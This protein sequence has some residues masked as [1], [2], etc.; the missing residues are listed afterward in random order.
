[1]IY[2]VLNP[3]RTLANWE[4]VKQNGWQGLVLGLGL[5]GMISYLALIRLSARGSNDTAVH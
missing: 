4:A 1:L 3:F 5:V 2:D